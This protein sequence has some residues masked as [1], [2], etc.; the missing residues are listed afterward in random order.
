MPQESHSAL[1]ISNQY[2][3]KYKMRGD[4]RFSQSWSHIVSTF[5]CII[6]RTCKAT[7]TE[8]VVFCPPPASYLSIR[9]KSPLFSNYAKKLF[10]FSYLSCVFLVYYSRVLM[11][12]SHRLLLV[13]MYDACCSHLL[14][15]W[16]LNRTIW[17]VDITWMIT[18]NNFSMA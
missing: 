17:K 13:L 11:A 18:E 15:D 9:I 7:L 10:Q 1:N 5:M 3:S 14:I 2:F 6:I 16:T 12:C 4:G 8:D